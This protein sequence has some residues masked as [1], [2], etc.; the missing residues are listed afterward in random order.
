MKGYGSQWEAQA[1]AFRITHR[2]SRS[3]CPTRK[4]HDPMK[5]ARRS[6]DRW[7]RV[8]RSKRTALT[9]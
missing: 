6:A 3:V 9:S 5:A 4:G 8:R 7:P 1:K 2:T